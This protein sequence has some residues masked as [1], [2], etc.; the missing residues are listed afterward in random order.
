MIDKSFK[1]LADKMR[2]FYYDTSI[3]A[4]LILLAIAIAVTSFKEL[5]KKE[6]N[7]EV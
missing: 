4:F 3:I 7:E 6:K 2:R 1:K 5:F